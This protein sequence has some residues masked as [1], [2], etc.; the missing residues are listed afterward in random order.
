MMTVNVFESKYEINAHEMIG[1]ICKDFEVKVTLLDV[2]WELPSFLLLL[3]LFVFF[4][5]FPTAFTI[6]RYDLF[7]RRLP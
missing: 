7:T 2:T 1:H 4:Q 6:Y 3:Y 5:F